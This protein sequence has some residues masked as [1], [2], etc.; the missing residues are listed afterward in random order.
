MKN[1]VLNGPFRQD[2]EYWFFY[3]F[4]VLNYYSALHSPG[5]RSCCSS[6]GEQSCSWAEEQGADRRRRES[7]TWHGFRG[8]K[9]EWY[10]Y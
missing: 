4:F 9:A 8:G 10:N 5:G 3:G 2:N 1:A 6:E 7:I